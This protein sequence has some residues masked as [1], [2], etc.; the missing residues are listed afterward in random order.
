MSFSNPAHTIARWSVVGMEG[1]W[2]KM[3]D[4]PKETPNT[5]DRVAPSNPV[6]EVLAAAGFQS[7]P[8]IPH[9]VVLDLMHG[10]RLDT[11]DNRDNGMEFFLFRNPDS[12]GVTGDEFPSAT[13]RVPQGVVFH[14]ETD[15]QGPPP[16]TIH[17]HGLEPTP[18]NDGVGHCSFEIGHYVYQLQPQFIGTYFAHCHRNTMQHFEFGLYFLIIIEPKDAY[19]AT[20]FNQAIPIGHCRDGRRRTAANLTAFP[21]FPDFNAS[22]V[23]SVDPWAG[24]P[25]LKFNTNPHGNTVAY[26]IEALWVLDDRDSAWSDLGDNARATYPQYG[27]RPGFNDN[28]H[29]NGENSPAQPDDFFAFNDFNA[30]YWY[31]TGV[32]VEAHKGGTA[33]IAPN[34]VIPAA[35][36]SGVSGSQVSINGLTNQTIL[37]RCLDAAYNST[38][39]TF[40][41]DVLIIAWDGRALG[42]APFGQNHP[43]LVPA[44]TPIKQTTARRFDALIRVSAPVNS[45]ATV[46]FINNRGQVPGEAQDVLV[47]ARIP[48]SIGAS[49]GLTATSG[50]NG[51]VTPAGSTR[52]ASGGSRTYSVTPNPG[53]TIA[54]L[55]VDGVQIAAAASYTFTNVTANHSISAVFAAVVVRPTGTISINGGAATTNSTTATLTLSA[56]SSAGAVTLM[57]FSKDGVNFFPFEPYATTRVVT[58]LP[59]DGLKTMSVRFK[60]SAGNLSLAISDSIT[61]TSGTILINGGASITKSTSGVLTISAVAG[62]TQMQF[63]KNGG[64]WYPWEPYASTRNFT[65]TSVPGEADGV[66]TI[67]VRF[68]NGAGAISSPISA[69]I[70]LD[71]TKPTGTIQFTGPD[72]ISSATGTLAL[73]VSDTNS[74]TEMQ[75]AK[76]GSAFFPWEPF[77]ATRNVALA[78]G[79][80]TLTVRFRDAAGNISDS[81]AAT[82]T[83]I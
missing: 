71:T 45:Y 21:Q 69:S 32:A 48:I 31:V 17:W 26:D 34:V 13:L 19:F 46:K 57:Q 39:V 70:M 80:N 74:V 60:D 72:P 27:T 67:Q 53:F 77:A 41:V 40:P 22:P 6:P 9:T 47:T 42:V 38:E 8:D 75:L 62:T 11:W 51:I 68:R 50:A 52:I 36:N 20:Q 82:K 63:S 2:A 49:F 23:D 64:S 37:V 10:E 76:N 55:V 28:F 24:N 15:G 73:T 3:F 43:Y 81:Y 59:G 25:N 61:L 79:L 35:L 14:C 12:I 30:D 58:L 18:M 7:P 83:R 78:L 54:A 5:P 1:M 65:L 33:T 56:T 44:G 16:H 29:N 4:P 66:K